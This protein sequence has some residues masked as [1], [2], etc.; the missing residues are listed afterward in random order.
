VLNTLLLIQDARGEFHVHR[1]GCRDL[2]LEK[3]RTGGCEEPSPFEVESFDHRLVE[4]AAQRWINESYGQ[5]D[6]PREYAVK[7]F[8]CIR[9]LSSP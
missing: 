2:A 9:K 8:P 3:Y 6:D 5:E 1:P 4:A 7:I